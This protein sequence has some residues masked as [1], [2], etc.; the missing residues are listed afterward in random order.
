MK[1]CK[2]VEAFIEGNAQWTP[3]LEQLRKIL[4]ATPLEECVKWGAPC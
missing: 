4:T 1:S 3:E 2:T